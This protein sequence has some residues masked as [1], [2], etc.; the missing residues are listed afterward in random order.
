MRGTILYKV[1]PMVALSALTLPIAGQVARSHP[2]ATTETHVRTAPTP[3]TA[4]YTITRVQV[5]ANG[6]TITRERKEVKALDSQGRR[7]TALTLTS[8]SGDRAEVT[9]V[10]VFDPVAHT[11]TQWTSPGTRATVTAMPVPESAHTGPAHTC[12]PMAPDPDNVHVTGPHSTSTTENLGTAEILGVEA[13]GRRT[14]R[15]IPAGAV[16]NE[17]PLETTKETWT[18]VA[19]GLNSL[20]V[21]DVTDDPRTGKSTRELTQLTQGDPDP[22]TFQPPEGYEIVTKDAPGCP[23]EAATPPTSTSQ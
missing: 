22:S 18:A 13:R 8:E 4:E 6:T 10:F 3:Y 15:T 11:Q 9:H 23:G 1:L 19:A 12:S 16:G 7:M 2:S 20:L 14:T 5:L 21:R 17:E